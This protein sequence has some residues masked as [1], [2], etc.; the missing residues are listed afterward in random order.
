MDSTVAAPLGPDDPEEIGPFKIIGLLGVGGMGEVY[1]GTG[2]T[3][4]VAVKRVRPHLVAAERFKREVGILHRVP[5]GVA[6][7]VW[8]SDSTA[9]RPWFATEYVP[10]LTADEAVRLNG[11]LP[12]DALWL[13]LAEAAAQLRAVHEAR[14][15]HRD[16]KPA[17]I[18]LVRGGVKLIDFGIAR[19]ADQAKLTRSGSGYGTRGYTAPEQD[20]GD[21]LVA[22]PADVYS[23]GALLLYAASGRTPGVIPDVEAMRAEVPDLADIVE[24]CLVED[25][26]AR[27]TA[28]ELV[29]RAR[30]HVLA[31]DPSWPPLVMQ[32]I[33]GRE[34]FAST[35]VGRMATL[36]PPPL[37]E[38]VSANPDAALTP[39][40]P[41]APTPRA[42]PEGLRRH[43]S[44][45]IATVAIVLIA[46]GGVTVF[47]LL[48]NAPA[49]PAGQSADTPRLDAT[50]MGAAKG[51]T[52]P[53]P[54]HLASSS[55]TASS[56]PTNTAGTTARAA[57]RP[58][59]PSTNTGAPSMTAQPPAGPS[60]DHFSISGSQVSV[61]GCTGWMDFSGNIYGTLSAGQA[62]CSANVITTNDSMGGNGTMTLQTSDY[63]ETNSST[64]FW[65]FGTYQFTRQICIWNQA[66]PSAQACSS[67]YT[68]DSGTVSKG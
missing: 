24:S 21:P 64:A 3:G 12:A 7:G 16:L 25:P 2:E 38:L 55:A 27:P 32:H 15:V 13:L 11:P 35:P 34:E 30:E 4:Y 51:Q 65:Y 28:I 67:T 46:A 33:F 20:A 14:I 42:A 48:P 44:F 56:T 23:L 53:S 8:A 18:M 37:A 36:E 66:S 54:S 6:P 31:T 59:R 41:A 9:S 62:S 45:L 26:A 43:L 17:N 49:H 22:A 52:S 58:S 29:D 39:A 47:V 1:L 63:T 61:P 50:P 19:A 68:D 60:N 57:G 5:D 40:A 10:G